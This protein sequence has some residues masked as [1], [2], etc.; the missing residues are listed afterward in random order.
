MMKKW[1]KRVVAVSLV[2]VLA[3]GILAG[4]G[5]KT[6]GRNEG[7]DAGG[8]DV[9]YPVDTE[10]ELSWYVHA[11]NTLQ[12]TLMSADESPFHTGLEDVTGIGI[13]WQFAA[14]GSD[15]IAAYN[16]LLQDEVLPHIISGAVFSNKEGN[17]LME[18]G[19]I[20]DLTDYVKKY[21]PDYWAY[22]TDPAHEEEYKAMTTR[23][24]KLWGFGMFSEKEE[25]LT[26]IGPV[27][28]K[29]WL[30]ECGLQEP[31]TLADWENVLK[32]FKERYGATFSFSLERYNN[33]G[34]ASGTGAFTNFNSKLF[35]DDNDEVQNANLQEEWR[36]MLK[37]LNRW[38]D[39][40]LIDKD[41]ATNTDTTVR[42]KV[43]RG[44]VGVS[45]TAMS[46]ITVWKEDA[47][48]RNMKADWVGFEYPRTAEGAPTTYINTQKTLLQNNSGA[49]IT[50]G[51]SEQ[52]IIAACKLLN[53]GFTQD[54]ILY[55][56]YGTEGVSYTINAEGKPVFTDT[57]MKHPLGA[58]EAFK[59]YTGAWSAG[60]TVQQLDMV[61][62]KNA[63][64]A[65]EAVQKWMKNTISRE[66]RVPS[67]LYAEEDRDALTDLES[68]VDTY[69][70]EMALKFVTG[71]ESLDDANWNAYK[72]QVKD[73]G[74][75]K[76]MQY[77]RDAY[78]EYKNRELKK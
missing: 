28:R 58:T 54:G 33:G 78:K 17:R 19:L 8:E 74:E 64:E 35:L 55:W 59:L 45:I 22:L 5:K 42:E 31:V 62:Q 41:F 38:Y 71:Q 40:G 77:Y 25:N 47:E 21:A 75:D 7:L 63:P 12:P 68:K 70:E 76:M 16:L 18:A 48:A 34:I 1:F 23:D 67:L 49:V 36:E 9:S 53:Y 46:Q 10:I 2:S 37:V 44:E 27:I 50:S 32:T 6:G 39:M 15:G 66:K 3:V 43:L 61:Y 73:Y 26:Y 4:C 20:V 65:V 52:E 60:V 69:I 13:D 56:N 57:V 72:K 30:D 51:C 24:G 14:A 11:H 29:D